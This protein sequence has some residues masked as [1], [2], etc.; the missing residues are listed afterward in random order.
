[1]ENVKEQL[2]FPRKHGIMEELVAFAFLTEGVPFFFSKADPAKPWVIKLNVLRL[3]DI[4]L[5]AV[6]LSIQ[7]SN[8]HGEW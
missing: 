3:C 2:S 7:F 8:T 4:V 5:C 1:M 6:L